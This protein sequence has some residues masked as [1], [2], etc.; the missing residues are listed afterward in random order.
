MN[1]ITREKKIILC[2]GTYKQNIGVAEELNSTL[3]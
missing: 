3:R 2:I 1:E